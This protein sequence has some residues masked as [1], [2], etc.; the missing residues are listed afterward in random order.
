MQ[1]RVWLIV[2]FLVYFTLGCSP[3]SPQ[4]ALTR[5]LNALKN[6]DLHTAAQYISSKDIEAGYL[7][8][9]EKQRNPMRTFLEKYHKYRIVNTRIDHD[10]AYIKV[11]ST[12]LSGLWIY[13]YI[14]LSPGLEKLN[15]DSTET[16]LTKLAK[17]G[18]IPVSTDTLT[19]TLIK[20]NGRWK[21][22]VSWRKRVGIQKF[23]KALQQ[24]MEADCVNLVQT[25]FS[26]LDSVLPDSVE[27]EYKLEDSTKFSDFKKSVKN[28]IQIKEYI[29][30]YIKVKNVYVRKTYSVYGIYMRKVYGAIV[31]LGDKTVRVTK[32][33]V[34]YLDWSGKPIQ[35]ETHNIKGYVL[36]PGYVQTFESILDIDQV[37]S[38]SGK[39]KV[40]VKDA[41]FSY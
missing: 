39:V 27:D 19:Y 20:E 21:I 35:E 32:I 25:Y 29:K 22:Y 5:Y 28:F 31:N 9:L 3:N 7:E 30:K 38:W 11:L 12:R 36:K 8:H 41:Y 16:I 23:C 10:T 1:Y 4:K 15:W 33:V 40:V 26:K 37:P 6:D 24:L 14:R 34:Y 13:E 2:L 18:K 17:S